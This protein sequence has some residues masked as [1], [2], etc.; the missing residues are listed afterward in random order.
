M[1]SI[2]IFNIWIFH[3]VYDNN[4]FMENLLAEKNMKS[5]TNEERFER[6]LTIP[7]ACEVL[8]IS[9]PTLLAMRERGEIQ[10]VRLGGRVFIHPETIRKIM[11][12]PKNGSAGEKR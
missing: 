12:P 5:Q 9:R 3:I 8:R 7:E 11:A 10:I 4:C 6:L 2:R 1:T